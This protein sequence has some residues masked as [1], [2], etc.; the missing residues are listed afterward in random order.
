MRWLLILI[1]MSSGEAASAQVV[2]G[3][4]AISR[5]SNGG[6]VMSAEFEGSGNPHLFLTQAA[7]GTLIVG[8]TN[9]AWSAKKTLYQLHVLIDERSWTAPAFGSD[10]PV[11][12][13]M[14]KV[15]ATFRKAFG[16]GHTITFTS[17]AGDLIT[18][19]SL[20][21]TASALK[22]L[23][24]CLEYARA[25]EKAEEEKA[26]RIAAIPTDPFGK[27]NG[28]SKAVPLG[29]PL[30]WI[31]SDDYPPFAQIRHH[32]G[33]VSIRLEINETGHVSKCTVTESSGYQELDEG[34]CSLLSQRARFTP[35]LDDIGKPTTDTF[36]KR[37]QWS[38]PSE[39]LGETSPPFSEKSPSKG[40]AR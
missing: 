26:A 7:N 29:D 18:K 11:P 14:I 12:Q 34:T 22:R 39:H 31:R 19:F 38:L 28:P 25:D 40:T 17:A 3:G 27:L 16:A 13:F 8:A 32:E 21:G 15:D 9:T 37:I 6:C 4:W 2:S 10:D 30:S 5:D 1:A 20:N 24:T 36:E 33:A 35:A 23:D